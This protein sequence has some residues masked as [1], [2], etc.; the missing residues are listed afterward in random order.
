MTECNQKIIIA[1]KLK[2]LREEILRLTK[3]K[4]NFVDDPEVLKFLEINIRRRQ[5]KIMALHF[6][7]NMAN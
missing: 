7:Y 3:E 5:T 4:E 2:N 1:N 6:E